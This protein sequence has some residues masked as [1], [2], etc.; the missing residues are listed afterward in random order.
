MTLMATEVASKEKMG[1]SNRFKTP[2]TT[3]RV[4]IILEIVLKPEFIE[5]T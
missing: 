5:I 1:I 3:Q 2:T 4:Y